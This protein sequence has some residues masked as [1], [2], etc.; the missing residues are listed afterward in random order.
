MRVENNGGHPM[1]IGNP[2]IEI[3]GRAGERKPTPPARPTLRECRRF[4]FGPGDKA[5]IVARAAGSARRKVWEI[6]RDGSS[7]K[8]SGGD[9]LVILRPCRSFRDMEL[10]HA[11]DTIAGRRDVR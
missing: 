1:G 6:D 11:D 8:R 10:K 2:A 5:A 7:R 4:F 9:V 3:V